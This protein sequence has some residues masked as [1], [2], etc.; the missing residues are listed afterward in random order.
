MK[1]V[2]YSCI[3]IILL[4]SGAAGANDTAILHGIVYEWNTFD[5]LDNAV[6]EVNSTPLQSIV[7]KYG[8]YSFELLPGDYL[9]KASYYQDSELTHSTEETVQITGE[10]NYVLDL[11]LLPAYP[12][13]LSYPENQ[14][15]NDIV[16]GNGTPEKSGLQV[17]GYLILAIIA[18]TVLFHAFMYFQ[19]LHIEKIK[20]GYSK[21]EKHPTKPTSDMLQPEKETPE[22]IDEIATDEIA[23]DETVTDEIATDETVTDEMVTDETVTDETVTDETVT[24]ETVTDET[25]T[26]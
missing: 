4:L 3:A 22:V 21:E 7:A 17:L 10:G 18:I 8:V 19:K 16:G 26:D 24:D 23:T 9:I 5:P 6:V 2:F 20:T 25:V 11:L 1:T 13:E 14:V 12:E 15:G